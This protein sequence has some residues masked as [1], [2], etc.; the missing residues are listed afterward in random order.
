VAGSWALYAEY[1]LLYIGE[2]DINSAFNTEGAWDKKSPSGD[3]QVKNIFSLGG[4]YRFFR[5]FSLFAEAAFLR[6]R[7]KKDFQLAAGARL[8]LF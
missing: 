3:A 6:V 4:W 5:G 2:N 1:R 7:E 8:K